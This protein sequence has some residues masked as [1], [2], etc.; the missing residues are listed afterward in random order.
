MPSIYIIISYYNRTSPRSLR[1]L[2]E[3]L[4]DY[5]DLI[6][7][8][9]N[10]ESSNDVS[11]FASLGV[12]YCVTENEGMNIGAWTKGYQ[13]WPEADFY[14]FLQDECYVKRL[15]FLPQIISQFKADQKVGLL[16]ETLNYRWNHD[17]Q[18]LLESPIN[19]YETQHEIDDIQSKRVDCYLHHM[20]RWKIDPGQSALHL[21]SLVWAL[22]AQV[23]R[24]LGGFPIGRN[25]GECIAAEI[26]VSRRLISLG[27]RIS[28]FGTQPF[29][30][31][32]HRE[33]RE[34]GLSKIQ[35]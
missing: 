23:M 33:W 32:G 28:Q 34:D 4:S 9:V 29:T 5:S 19:R 2:L 3:Q 21:R 16:G 27:Y 6:R 35:S 13:I 18:L 8:V 26:A 11:S 30:Y 17:W 12:K 1:I 15:D 14:I 22:P 25:K 20:R 7:L 10:V 31:F 24:R